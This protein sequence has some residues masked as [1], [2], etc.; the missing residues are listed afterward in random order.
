DFSLAPSVIALPPLSA[1]LRDRLRGGVRASALPSEE[2]ALEHYLEARL[3]EIDRDFAAAADRFETLVAR[4]ASWPIPRPVEPVLGLARVLRAAG[5][6]VDAEERLR[7]ALSLSMED[8]PVWEA[9]LAACL[10]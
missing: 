1:E 7:A 6:T 3:S 10:V 5:R 8:R 4:A 2:D 9:W